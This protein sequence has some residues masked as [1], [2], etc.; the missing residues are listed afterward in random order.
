MEEYEDTRRCTYDVGLCELGRRGNT[1]V[2]RG[3]RIGGDIV[4]ACSGGDIAGGE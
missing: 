4:P 2:V 1:L 3:G